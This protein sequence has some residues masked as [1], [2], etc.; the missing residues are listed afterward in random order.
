M[1][2]SKN[3]ISN[4]NWTW[5]IRQFQ[6]KCE[7]TIF[8]DESWQRPFCWEPDRQKE[9]IC[10]LFDQRQNLTSITLVDIAS[11]E[12]YCKD[13]HE[14]FSLLYCE[15]IREYA[16]WAHYI[17]T[18]GNNRTETLWS[19]LRDKL[20]IKGRF[21]D[22]NREYEVSE[23]T[24]FSGL[25]EDLQ[26]Y[27][28]TISM[29]I[30]LITPHSL[31][32]IKRYCLEINSQNSWNA[33][34]RRNCQY[35]QTTPVEWARKMSKKYGDRFTAAN[36]PPS[37]FSYKRRN[38]DEF[39]LQML[40]LRESNFKDGSAG[41]QDLDKWLRKQT[42]PFAKGLTKEMN[43]CEKD[44]EEVLKILEIQHKKMK[45]RRKQRE[46]YSLYRDCGVREELGI[47]I[48]DWKEYAEYFQTS[49]TKREVEI[50]PEDADRNRIRDDKSLS[51]D[52]M[53]TKIHA[54]DSETY[55]YY[56]TN[57]SPL[58]N[59][60]AFACIKF[61]LEN[62]KKDLLESNIIKED[63][64]KTYYS[65]MEKAAKWV[66]Q[67]GTC[68]ITAQKISAYALF[69]PRDEPPAEGDHIIPLSL[70]GETTDGNIQVTTQTANRQKGSKPFQDIGGI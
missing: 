6:K 66:K 53:I 10:S 60:K 33:A 17:S 46:I 32:A 11:F 16:P 69:N 7:K 50:R 26:E 8:L 34:E 18:D 57:L 48:K 13:A 38:F 44:F 40:W 41:T 19:F 12:S 65:T 35:G 42:T 24:V 67:G 29:N 43:E 62:D 25:D 45:K 58:Q 27:F 61:T 31:D 59:E 28:L 23:E 36:A 68:A 30:N 47:V 3:G 56:S 64:K 4:N 52:E 63:K 49:E 51:A 14:E 39:A 55:I 70:G 37:N 20:T 5:T 2:A 22:S 9:Y 54:L 1:I 21:K 15:G